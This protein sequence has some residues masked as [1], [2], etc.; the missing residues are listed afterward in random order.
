LKQKSFKDIFDEIFGLYH[1]DNYRD[2]DDYQIYH[3]IYILL[4]EIEEKFIKK[5]E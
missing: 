3:E 5:K 2:R 1:P 4:V